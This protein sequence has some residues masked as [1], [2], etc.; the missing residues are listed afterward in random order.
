V[1]DTPENCHILGQRNKM[2]LDIHRESG[3]AA[4]GRDLGI[5]S[6][7]QYVT[8]ATFKVSGR[9]SRIRHVD[10]SSKAD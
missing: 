4:L 10:R 7:S 3:R 9:N 6:E 2:E 5:R 8:R 1:D